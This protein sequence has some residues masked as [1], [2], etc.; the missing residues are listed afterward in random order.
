MRRSALKAG[1]FC[2][3]E[4]TNSINRV[5]FLFHAYDFIDLV[6]TCLLFRYPF[7]GK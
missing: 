6:A 4:E 7:C 5:V 2:N 3:D 1:L